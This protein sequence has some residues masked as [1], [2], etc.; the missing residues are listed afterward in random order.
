MANIK[1]L[2]KILGYYHRLNLG[3]VRY[4]GILQEKEHA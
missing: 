4:K 3:M 2:K 1:G